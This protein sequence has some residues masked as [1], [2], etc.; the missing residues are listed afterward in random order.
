MKVLVACEKWQRV[1]I[2]FRERGHEAYSCDIQQCGG[3]HPEWHIFG[4]CLEV[5]NGNCTF[6]TQDG[7]THKINGQWDLLICHPPC[8]FLTVSG[9]R[10]F[11][12]KKYGEAAIK[13]QKDRVD[14]IN[15]FMALVNADCKR[16]AVE[17]PI[18]IMS[19]VYRKPDQIIQPY[20]FGNPVSKATCLWLKNLPP[21]QPTKIVEPELIHSGGGVRRIF[22]FSLARC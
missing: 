8:T 17:N 16:I 12:V 5:I 9:N 3:E 14:A 22:W 11:N 18:G 13:R 1:C 10:W 21:L 19:N 20:W 2:A 7:T 4:D 6:T 15:F